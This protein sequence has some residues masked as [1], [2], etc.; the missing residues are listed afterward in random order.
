MK[1][2]YLEIEQVPYVHQEDLRN[3]LRL[4][5]NLKLNL[6]VIWYCTFLV[7]GVAVVVDGLPVAPS[8]V[9]RPRLH[10]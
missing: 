4:V 3:K 1:L 9:L 6:D 8:D 7:V 10:G 2:I 5:W